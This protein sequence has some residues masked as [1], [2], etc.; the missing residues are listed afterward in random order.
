MVRSTSACAPSLLRHWPV[1]LLGFLLACL[2]MPW[3]AADT[4]VVRDA[5]A[6]RDAARRAR[7]G[8]RIELA[9]GDYTGGIHL[10]GLHG[11]KG[12]P[13]VIAAQDRKRPPVI[14]GG[15]S[16]L[17][18]TDPVHVVL[19]DLVFE[20]A[21]GNGLNI[22]D[23]G[24]FDSPA[25]DLTLR[26]LTVR[27]VGPRGN[28]DG[29]KL[30]GVVDAR[31]EDCLVE[32]WGR[33]GS[34]VDM[35]GCHRVT[36]GGC[37]FRHERGMARGSGVQAKGGSRDITIRG[38]RFEHAGARAVNA[39]GS[40]GLSYFRPGVEGR[41]GPLAEAGAIRVCGNTFI[42][43]AAAVAF[44]GVDGAEVAWNTIY[45]PGRWA[46]R[47]L[48]E[49]RDERFVPSRRGVVKANLIVFRREAWAE[50]GINV[51][52]GAAPKTFEF[53][54]NAWYCLDAP[55]RTRSFV[56][57]PVGETQGVYGVDPHLVDS[58]GGNLRI[59]K[60]SK[61]RDVGAEAC[62]KR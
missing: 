1:R 28:R 55:V 45:E 15:T 18:L 2:P 44:V 22:D 46:F 37:T 58:A 31:L 57:M 13:V 20:G 8:A 36:I 21:T 34:A 19:E 56:R 9:P 14:R 12:R 17:Q 53:T 16:G 26:R 33:A 47:I 48:Q 6:L 32:N 60:R 5:A 29:I 59:G 35:V 23:G 49:N 52:E 54:Q 39:G 41:K 11:K 62:G 3:A 61:L 30:S 27:N 51:G 10:V 38:N 4:V 42:G 40:T 24:S 7:P 50:G 25:R 43:S